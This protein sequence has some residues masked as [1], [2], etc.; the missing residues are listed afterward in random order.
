MDKDDNCPVFSK[1][2]YTVKGVGEDWP[3]GT[4][5][6]N[7]TATDRDEGTNAELRYAI[8]SGDD[9]GAFTVDSQTGIF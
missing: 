8:K 6:L 4:I 2:V 3:R 9:K 1:L 5:I 7:V